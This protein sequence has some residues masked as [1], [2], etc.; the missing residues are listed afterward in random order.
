MTIDPCHQIFEQ[1]QGPLEAAWSKLQSEFRRLLPDGSQIR[2][3]VARNQGVTAQ[4]VSNHYYKA[5]RQRGGTVSVVPLNEASEGKQPLWIAW[6]EVWNETPRPRR[7]IFQTTGLTIFSGDAHQSNKVQLFRAEWPGVRGIVND[8]PIFDAQVA[9]HPHWQFYA[10]Q[11][12]AS[13]GL[14]NVERE[15]LKAVL[16]DAV[17]AQ[18]F[19]ET[20]LDSS[21]GQSISKLDWTWTKMH[22]ASLAEW[23]HSPWDGNVNSI[24]Q[25]ARGPKAISEIHN[26]VLSC[27]RYIS[28]ELQRN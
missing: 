6:T 19:D 2:I 11:S 14:I 21:D 18:E 5:E 26:W 15:K 23:S 7:L 13:H 12:I 22:F 28:R 10:I 3:D 9:W 20:L 27:V 25:H 17:V 24:R 16:D 1:G 8:E 4:L